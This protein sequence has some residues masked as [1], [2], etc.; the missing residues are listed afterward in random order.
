MDDVHS[1]VEVSIFD[2]LA[3]TET[4]AARDT[5]QTTTLRP[6]SAP[7]SQ[8][9][10]GYRT[11][12]RYT[13]LIELIQPAWEGTGYVARNAYNWSEKSNLKAEITVRP[14]IACYKQR[15][16]GTTPFDLPSQEDT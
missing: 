12:G 14:D 16:D 13:P 4:T 11:L 15:E 1:L 7:Q 6:P 8:K 5:T 9:L 2:I 10:F 3:D